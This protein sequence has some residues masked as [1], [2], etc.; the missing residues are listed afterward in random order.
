MNKHFAL[1]GLVLVLAS[2]NLMIAGKERTLASG[3]TML[4]ELAPV[5]PRSLI[6][7]DYMVLRYRIAG[8]LKPQDLGASGG[9]RIVVVLD[10]RDVASF[11]RIDDGR[12]LGPNERVLAYRRRGQGLR[13]GAESFFFQEGQAQLYQRARYGE[14]KVAASGRSVLVGLRDAELKRLGRE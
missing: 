8:A 2:V 11:V 7:G 12:G 1:V 6:Q 4:L 13:L 3:Q 5:D 9:G 10:D 14:L